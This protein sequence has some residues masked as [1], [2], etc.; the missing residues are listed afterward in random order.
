M[1]DAYFAAGSLSPDEAQFAFGWG[2]LLQLAD[3]LQDLQQDLRQ[4]ILTVF[5]Q[6]AARTPLGTP[7]D[8]LTTR[9]LSFGQRVMR[10]VDGMP[11]N[12]SAVNGA[13]C[14]TQIT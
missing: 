2:A 1:A 13:S 11:S 10:Q 9:T 14:E 8:N 3:D 4:G 12:H 7:L 6:A 5:T